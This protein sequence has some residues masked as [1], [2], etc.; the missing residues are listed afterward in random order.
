V[1]MRSVVEKKRLILFLYIYLQDKYIKKINFAEKQNFYYAVVPLP[2][3]IKKEGVWGEL[4]VPLPAK[5][6]KG[7]GLGE[8]LVPPAIAIAFALIIIKILIF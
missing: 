7:G 4:L 1:Y 5:I 6:K 3:K 2:A 8:L